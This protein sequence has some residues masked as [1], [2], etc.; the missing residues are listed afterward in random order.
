MSTFALVDVR[1]CERACER[2]GTQVRRC[3]GGRARAVARVR[4]CAGSRLGMCEC[5][6]MCMWV[7]V[8]V[9]ILAQAVWLELKVGGRIT[10]LL[11]HTPLWSL[12]FA[13]LRTVVPNLP[14]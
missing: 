11:P 4:V 13:S 9:A 1:A 8:C 12:P 14:G 7:P 5:V 10:P 2:A 6:C 3:V